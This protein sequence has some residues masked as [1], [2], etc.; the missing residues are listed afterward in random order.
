MRRTKT[1][2]KKIRILLS[3]NIIIINKSNIKIFFVDSKF[4]IIINN[5][6]F[7]PDFVNKK[8]ILKSKRLFDTAT[9]KPLA[10][11]HQL[12]KCRT[13]TCRRKSNRR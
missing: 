13:A 11:A 2:I 9:I 10:V 4:H 1:E 3:F 7:F 6:K 5:N 8:F 12:V